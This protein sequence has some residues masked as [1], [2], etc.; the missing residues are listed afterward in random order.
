MMDEK[1]YF[2]AGG[3]TGGHIYPALAIAEQVTQK[4]DGS[5]MLF[6]CSSREIDARIL[7]KSGYEFKA[8]GGFSS[9]A[10]SWSKAIISSNIS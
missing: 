4:D 10:C 7:S 3:G 6:F 1:H 8:P 2:F 5:S 9:F